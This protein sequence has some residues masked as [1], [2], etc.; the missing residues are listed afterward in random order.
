MSIITHS[1]D[2][3]KFYP[4]LDPGNECAGGDPPSYDEAIDISCV[5]EVSWED[6]ITE[7]T[8]R[9]DNGICKRVSRLDEVLVTVRHTGMN[10]ELIEAMRNYA[11]STFTV[12]SVNG[13]R[14]E[15][16]FDQSLVRGA[17]IA[18]SPDPDGTGDN[19]VIFYNVEITTG[20]GGAFSD[21]AFRESTFTMRADRSLYAPCSGAYAELI[22][23]DGVVAIPD[24]FPGT[25]DY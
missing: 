18:R 19:H 15:R 1:I 22:H 25:S 7:A 6:Q 14:I 11:L 17:I 8:A 4:L 23:D 5:L 12:D 10:P 24:T 20:P 16:S 13:R 2:D 3:A 9:G 21:D